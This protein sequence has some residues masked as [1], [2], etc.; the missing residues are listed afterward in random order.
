MA[1][2]KRPSAQWA[3]YEEL[4]HKIV[5]E[6]MPHA[7]VTLDD[8][9]YGHETE[10]PRQI[11]VSAKWTDQGKDYLL[12]VQ[13]KDLASPA[14]INTVGTF[15]SV[16]QDVGAHKGVLIC[17]GGFSKKARTYARNLGIGLY[18]LHDASSRDWALELTVPLIWVSLNPEFH[19]SARF[20][21]SV[22]GQLRMH[23][24]KGLTFSEDGGRSRTTM[25]EY[26]SGLWNSGNLDRTPGAHE[27]Q[28]RKGLD[29]PYVDNRGVEVWGK[30]DLEFTYEVKRQSWLGQYRPS[31]CRGLLDFIESDLF[32]PSYVNLSDMPT[33]R[34]ETWIEVENPEEVAL[35]TVGM[36]I[37]TEQYRVVDSS[38]HVII[39]RF[40]RVN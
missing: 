12:I 40:E 8:H 32:I 35:K 15:R 7:V 39:Q 27:K 31:D 20:T 36:L 25:R 11:D 19:M 13:V 21:T 17:S 22:A 3:K 4:A 28:A 38:G 5:E 1:K 29:I 6:L 14:D 26:F 23:R 24:E 30:L 10:T 34:D 33:T 37:T 2:K 18:Q 9:P 16:I